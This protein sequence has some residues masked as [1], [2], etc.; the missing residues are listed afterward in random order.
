[1]DVVLKLWDTLIRL[2]SPVW[3]MTTIASLKINNKLKMI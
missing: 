1:M 3:P 2:F